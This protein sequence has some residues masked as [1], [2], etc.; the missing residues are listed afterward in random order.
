MDKKTV[1]D[2]RRGKHLAIIASDFEMEIEQRIPSHV[3]E[4]FKARLR[5]AFKSFAVEATEIAELDSN[6][7]LNDHAE[8]LRDNMTR[9]R[10]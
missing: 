2:R 9:T 7:E 3:A 4:K 10:A 8:A 1:I 6:T 5:G